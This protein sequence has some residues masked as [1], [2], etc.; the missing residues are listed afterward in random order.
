MPSSPWVS[1]SL[2]VS[3]VVQKK[4][5]FKKNYLTRENDDI[6]GERGSWV[7]KHDFFIFQI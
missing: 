1:V 2:I 3:Q 4:K 7:L 6:W 5:L